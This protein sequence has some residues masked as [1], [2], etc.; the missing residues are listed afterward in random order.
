MAPNPPPGF[1]LD[2]RSANPPPPPGFVHDRPPAPP[3]HVFTESVTSGSNPAV[4]FMSGLNRGLLGDFLGAPV[5]LFNAGLSLAGLGTSEP[6]GGSKF[7]KRQLENA[8]F[9]QT[10]EKGSVSERIGGEVGFG[11]GAALPIMA[12]G[13]RSSRLVKPATTFGEQLLKGAGARPGVF[14]TQEAIASVGGGLGVEVARFIDPD[15]ELSEYA[16]RLAGSLTASGATSLAVGTAK[17]VGGAI[18]PFTK[19]GRQTL[20][21][22]M[23]KG[24]TLNPKQAVRNLKAR[25]PDFDGAIFT[26][27]QLADDPGLLALER[28]VIRRSAELGGKFKAIEG[29]LNRAARNEVNSALARAKGSPE[30]MKDF[31]V[32]RISRLTDLVD[33]T[34]NLAT[35]SAKRT[36][37]DLTPHIGLP[38]TAKVVRAHIQN[39]FRQARA[40]ERAIW[41]AVYKNEDI[42]TKPVRAIVN[43]IRDEARKADAPDNVPAFFKQL[44]AKPEQKVVETGMMDAGGRP[45]TRTVSSLPKGAF[46]DVE[47]VDELLALRSRI[48]AEIRRENAKDA[49]NR[50]R[51]RNLQRVGDVVLDT[52]GS[53]ATP[54]AAA[55]RAFSLKLNDKFTRG[56]IG[57]ILGL[58]SQGGARVAPENTMRELFKPVET[59]AVNANA[60]VKATA[61]NPETAVAISSYVRRR[62][63]DAVDDGTGRISRAAAQ[64]FLKQN[65]EFLSRFPGL[66]NDLVDAT[67]NLDRM[68]RVIGT[69]EKVPDVVL[70]QSRAGLF[71][72]TDDPVRTVRQVLESASPVGGLKSLARAAAEDT[73]GR[74]TEGLKAAIAEAIIRKAQLRALDNAGVNLLSAAN[75]R[76]VLADSQVALRRS[77]LFSPGDLSR[78]QQVAGALNRAEKSITSQIRGGSD[79]AQNINVLTDMMTRVIGGRVGTGIAKGTGGNVLVIAGASI[80]AIRRVLVDAP[81]EKILQLVNEAIFDP[82][83]MRALLTKVTAKSAPIIVRKLRGSLLNVAPEIAPEEN[84]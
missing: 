32:N 50:M 15:S 34:I 57:R 75:F 45:I 33:D 84:Q 47:S 81:E 18:Q 7:L 25:P 60:L 13:A 46:K 40:T 65:D 61:E 10:P 29:Q 16:G 64:K 78:M 2:N 72:K 82:D 62:F 76:T 39:A 3:P 66:K 69:V 41:K 83:L 58:T 22:E 73:S 51:V 19:A 71:L 6:V 56:P 17:L 70:K 79:T 74:A 36:L 27:A 23:I 26:S 35:E 77:G 21:G 44:F 20:A 24:V 43:E 12:V 14:L 9:M 55:A 67:K 80:R 49:P 4:E 63:A 28:G 8:G 38:E 11:L 31:I 30:A 52:L 37:H 59:G 68:E 48:L 5:D 1:V 42:T 54:E 53:V